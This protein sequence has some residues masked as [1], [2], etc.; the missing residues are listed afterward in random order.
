MVRVIRVNKSAVDAYTAHLHHA[1]RVLPEAHRQAHNA[2]TH[3]LH[4]NVLAAV[5]SAGINP[6]GLGVFNR[7]GFDYVG[8]SHGHEGDALADT[9]Y[10]TVDSAPNAVLRTA[11][12]AAHPSA[13]GVYQRH[14][15]AGLGL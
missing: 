8:I 4:S 6:S 7:K 2:A 10:G 9:E 12:R 1:I 14:L 5:D 3:V 15:W 11:A 13:N